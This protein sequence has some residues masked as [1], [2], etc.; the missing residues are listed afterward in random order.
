MNGRDTAGRFAAGNTGRPA[1]ARNRTTMAVLELLEGQ[2]EAL[3]QRAVEL[4]LGGD[5]VALRLCLERVAPARK[6]NPVQFK[7]PQMTSARDAAEAAAAVL[8]AV[9][10]GDLTPTEG[11]QVMGLVDSYRRTI[12]V[13]ELEARVAALEG[14]KV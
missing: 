1:G 4:A 3:T 7:L 12:E 11:A 8:E 13:T 14:T 10:L 2:A 6:D 9:S 5:T